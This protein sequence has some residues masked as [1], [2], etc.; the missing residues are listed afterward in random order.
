MRE[1]I[2]K[3]IPLSDKWVLTINNKTYNSLTETLESY[4]MLTEFKGEFI[5]S[6]RTS[7]LFILNEDL[8]PIPKKYN[9]YG[10]GE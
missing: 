9:I 3:R 8:E 4:Y 7:Q 10:D 1:E 6:P 5:L 2:A